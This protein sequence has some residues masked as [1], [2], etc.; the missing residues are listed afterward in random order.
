METNTMEVTNTVKASLENENKEKWTLIHVRKSDGN[1]AWIMFNPH[2]LLI[3]D[4]EQILAIMKHILE[5]I[6]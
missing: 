5:D 6:Q 1:M 4:K 3:T 2:N